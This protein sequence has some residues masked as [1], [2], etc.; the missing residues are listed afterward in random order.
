MFIAVYEF[1]VKA[2]QET[3]FRHAW[4]QVTQMFYERC[5]SYGSRLHLTDHPGRFVGYAQWP[6]REQWAASRQ[7]D[8]DDFINTRQLMRDCLET[9]HTVYEMTVTDDELQRQ[10]FHQGKPD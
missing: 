10:L 9:S 4:R 1:Q 6:S 7:L 3:A 8:D 5:D 2:G